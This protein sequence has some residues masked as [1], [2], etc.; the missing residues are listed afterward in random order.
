MQRRPVLVSLLAVAGLAGAAQA[1]TNVPAGVH[2]A[3]E[4]WTLAGSPYRLQG[5][6]YFQAPATLTIDAGVI[7]ASLPA[8]EGSLAICQGAQ[9]FVNGTRS[10]P[11]IMTSTDDVATWTGTTGSGAAQIP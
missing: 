8:A 2:I 9:I 10:N 7:V 5:Q 11:V 4:H 6:V 1:Q 3:S